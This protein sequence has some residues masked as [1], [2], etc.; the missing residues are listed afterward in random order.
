LTVAV[1]FWGQVAGGSP[2]PHTG[3]G[4]ERVTPTVMVTGPA[5]FPSNSVSSLKRRITVRTDAAKVWALL[6]ARSPARNSPLNS[7]SSSFML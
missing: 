2:L 4:P 3:R 6:S 5:G 1:K 7:P